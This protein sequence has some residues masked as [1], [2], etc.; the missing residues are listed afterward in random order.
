MADNSVL[1]L[2]VRD[3]MGK[4]GAMRAL[5]LTAPAAHRYGEAVAAVPEGTDIAIEGRVESV[6]D[7]ILATG[8]IH[9]VATAEC[10]RCLEP[11]KVP[12]DADFQ[13]LFA[14]LDQDGYDNAVVDEHI[15][16]GPIVR[17]QVVLALPFQPMCSPDCPGLDPETGEKRPAGW[18]ETTED[19]IDPRWEALAA[20]TKTEP[21][22]QTPGETTE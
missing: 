4:P 14:Y 19:R 22:P 10:V 18:Q 16:L 13:E 7:G 21:T 6:H 12:I 5:E 3:L 11:L 1:V 15:D 2:P 9:T 8:D 17:D 20:L